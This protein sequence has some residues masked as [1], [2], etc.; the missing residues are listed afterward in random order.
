MCKTNLNTVKCL[1]SQTLEQLYLFN[2]CL[3]FPEEIYHF[4]SLSPLFCAVSQ[5]EVGVISPCIHF[6]AIITHLI[7]WKRERTRLIFSENL[8]HVHEDLKH[9]DIS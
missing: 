5:G 2:S 7:Y 6:L 9:G 1:V 4:W 8:K 3:L